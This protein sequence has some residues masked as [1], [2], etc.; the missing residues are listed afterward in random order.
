MIKTIDKMFIWLLYGGLFTFA[1]VLLHKD[2]TTN[3][4]IGSAITSVAAAVFAYLTKPLIEKFARY[5]IFL[6]IV[7]LWWFNIYLL[8]H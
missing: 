4:P 1:A 8:A 2:I 3:G 6:I 5:Q 7:L